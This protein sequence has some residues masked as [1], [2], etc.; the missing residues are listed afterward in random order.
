MLVG[1]VLWNAGNYVFFL[2][3]GRWLGPD[4]YGA[5]AALLAL[6]LIV[7]VPSGALQVAFSRRVAE[8]G[9]EGHATAAALFRR[10]FRWTIGVG[11]GVALL[12]YAIAQLAT[13]SIPTGALA[14]T[15][16]AIAPMGAFSMALGVLQGQHRF[17]AFAA[18][19]AMLGAP[20]PIVFA[21]LALGASGVIA[22]MGATAAAIFAAALLVVLVARPRGHHQHRLAAGEWSRFCRRM[23]PLAVGLSGIAVLLNVDVIVAKAALSDRT[24]GHFG[25]V[26]V[27]AKAITLVPQT[28]SWVLLPRIAKARSAAAPTGRLLAVGAIVTVA[29][30]VVAALVAWVAGT[31]IVRLAFGAEYAEGGSLLAPL[32]AVSALT[33]LLMVLMNHQMGRGLDG[34]VWAIAALAAF[35]VLL[36]AGF[37]GSA[38]AIIWVEALVG[39]AGIALHEALYS[40]GDGGLFRNIAQL[41]SQRPR[42]A[43]RAAAR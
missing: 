24:A 39:V 33:G 3:A 17:G 36:F 1:L 4:D 10:S 21:L 16:L 9:P 30:G 5:V 32:V 13:D 23:A 25:A 19:L 26:A 37:H 18:G 29:A 14:L 7:L 20:R 22:A 43:L 15:A 31:P 38:S 12:G 27:L 42:P 11:V 40:R 41:V 2:L 6:T 35:E 28:V 8:L 34:F